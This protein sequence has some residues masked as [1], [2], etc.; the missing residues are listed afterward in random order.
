MQKKMLEWTL[1]VLGVK[2]VL[3]TGLTLNSDQVVQNLLKFKVS[4]SVVWQLSQATCCSGENV[5]LITT[6]NLSY[7]NV[8][9]LLF[10]PSV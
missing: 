6:W 5:F 8:H 9:D 7:R 10:F 2:S 4:P 1:G 3:K